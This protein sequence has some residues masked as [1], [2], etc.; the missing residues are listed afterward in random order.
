MQIQIGVGE[1]QSYYETVLL[2][3]YSASTIAW[4]PSLQIFFM[5]AMVGSSSETKSLI[6]DGI[7]YS[8]A[9]YY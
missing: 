8:S 2:A 6:R 5:F 4:I 3:K 7:L 9:L 1:F